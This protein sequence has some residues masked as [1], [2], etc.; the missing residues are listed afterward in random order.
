M[1]SITEVEMKVSFDGLSVVDLE[2][3]SV[4]QVERLYGL[5]R[6]RRVPVS[7]MEQVLLGVVLRL[8]SSEMVSV[9]DWWFQAGEDV[10]SVIIIPAN[11]M[12]EVGAIARLLPLGIKFWNQPKLNSLEFVVSQK[13]KMYFNGAAWGTCKCPSCTG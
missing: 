7:D 5:E 9:E 12:I 13:H 2:Q 3:E 6:K 11:I 4:K 8:L 10:T 1:F